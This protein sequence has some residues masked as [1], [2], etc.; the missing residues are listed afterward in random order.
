MAFVFS[1]LL[2]ALLVVT[3]VDV[4]RRP[5]DEIRY[6]PKIAWAIIVIIFSPIG[7][8]LWWALGR[9]YPR[10]LT[11]KLR[12]PRPQRHQPSQS[13]PA[14]SPFDRRTTEEQLADLDREI[15]EARL[16]E[17]IAKRKKSAEEPPSSL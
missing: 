16:R 3:I 13:A 7:A 10:D 4:I 11:V 1:L 14:P 6:L 8:I 15:E 5:D 2:L 12:R 17:E 9:T